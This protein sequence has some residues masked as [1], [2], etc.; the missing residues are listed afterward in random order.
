MALPYVLGVD[1]AKA[2]LDLASEPAGLTAQF[3]ND[4]AGHAALVTWC[5]AQPVTLIVMEAT[6]GYEA[7]PAAA[8]AAA[9]FPVSI[10]NAR[11]VRSFAQAIGQ[12]AKTDRID[13]RV[14]ARFGAKVEPPVRPLTPPET[15]AL[16][17]LTQRRR[18]VLDM[19]HAEQHRRPQAD[20]VVR[21]RVDAHI[22][23]LEAELADTDATL[24]ATIAAS[25]MWRA[26]EE[27]LRQV[28]GVGSVLSRT[29]LAELPEL[30]QLSGREIAALVGVA[31]FARDSG[32]Q[33]GQRTTW[34]GRS[35]VRQKLYMATLAGTRY[36][37]VIR[38]HYQQLRAR[39]KP[40]KVALVACMRKLLVTLNAMVAHNTAWAPAT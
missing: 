17:A 7:A 9:G 32:T 37:P 27:Q 40:G 13:A 30:G 26:R 23:W 14:I 33:R 11:H 22:A 35:H 1:V 4:P 39:G 3:S 36:N 5:Q 21:P 28:P 16:A 34:G 24:A 19:L 10:A 18:Q 25:P 20:T 15:Q 12:L 38:A 2:T 31:P 6:G 29:L 8:L